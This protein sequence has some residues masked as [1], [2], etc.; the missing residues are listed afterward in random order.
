[1]MLQFD[2]PYPPSVNH[3]WR[4]VGAKTLISRAGR[5]FR[6]SVCSLLAARQIQPLVGPLVV[7]IDAFPPDRRRRDIDNITKALLDALQHGGAYHDDNQIVSLTITKRD[8]VP[9]GQTHVTIETAAC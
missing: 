7:R 4:R 9:G 6:A 5:T 2:L 8:V 1:M 3:Y